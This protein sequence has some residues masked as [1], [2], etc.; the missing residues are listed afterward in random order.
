VKNNIKT[1]LKQSIE[2]IDIRFRQIQILAE[3]TNE[4]KDPKRHYESSEEDI[5]DDIDQTAKYIYVE[6]LQYRGPIMHDT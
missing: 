6:E 5:G 2:T 1:T 4:D 3:N